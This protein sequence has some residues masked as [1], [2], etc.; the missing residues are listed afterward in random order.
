MNI[1]AVF[2][3]WPAVYTLA[4]RPLPYQLVQLI[5]LFIWGGGAISIILNTAIPILK[6]VFITHFDLI[7]DQDPYMLGKCI[8]NFSLLLGVTPLVIIYIY[9]S[10]NGIASTGTLAF[11]A[12]EEPGSRT[13]VPLMA[14]YSGVL[15]M[16]NMIV[17]V[18][19]LGFIRYYARKNQQSNV[20]QAAPS[21]VEVATRHVRLG[22]MLLVSLV[23]VSF[24]VAATLLSK[25]SSKA[26]LKQQIKNILIDNIPPEPNHEKSY[27][28]IDWGPT[29]SPHNDREGDR[30]CNIG[31]VGPNKTD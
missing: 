9:Q 30:G 18:F 5:M 17:L 16:I 2:S 6:I 27:F 4:F 1:S 12:G 20:Q 23:A 28:D 10:S 22:R 19:A 31:Q 11:L 15:F 26:S 24:S 21:Q 25:E 14:M 13:V 3:V 29:L 7:F 8:L